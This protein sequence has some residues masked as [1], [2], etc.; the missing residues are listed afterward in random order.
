MIPPRFLQGLRIALL[1]LPPLLA[2]PLHA[3]CSIN[4]VSSVAFGTYSVFSTTPTTATGSFAVRNCGSNNAPYTATLSTG[5][6]SVAQ[7]TLTKT[8]AS[9]NYNLYTDS[10]YTSIWGDGTTGTTVSGVGSN[11]STGITKTIYGSIPEGQD[12]P[13]GA[14]TDSITITITF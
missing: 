2:L 10:T 7:R 8:G 4:A 11:G 13:A 9:L 3:A 6:A 5:G 1:S 14:Y 12:V